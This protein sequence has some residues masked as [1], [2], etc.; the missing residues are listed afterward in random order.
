MA[1]YAFDGTANVDE[2]EDDKDTNVVRFTEL[3][4]GQIKYLEGVATEFNKTG[5]FL[6]KV[7]GYGANFW[8]MVN[9]KLM[10][11]VGSVIILI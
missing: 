4:D 5:N 8:L 2:V 11:M 7:T 9:E 1:L 10:R 6:S 3:Y